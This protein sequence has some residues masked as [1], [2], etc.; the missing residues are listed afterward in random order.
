M[1]SNYTDL[2][3]MI[4]ETLDRDDLEAQL[5]NFI[6][7]AESRHRREIR[8]RE[9]IKRAVAPAEERYLSLPNGFLEMKTL[10][11]LTDPVTAVQEVNL[12][13]MNRTR[14]ET[15]GKPRFYTVH[16]E[17]EFDRK[18][19]R[20]YTA[21]MIYYA[22]LTPLSAENPTNALLTRLPDVYLYGAL[23]AA[24][25]FLE[26]DERLAVW[27]QLYADARE[28]AN[29]MDRAKAGPLVAR[30]YGATP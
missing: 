27:S 26:H 29:A 14:I 12:D 28:Q 9:M 5:D 20:E 23:I 17:I 19:D 11:L 3:T 22:A 21:E 8:I 25:P 24:A 18:P 10:R 2:K 4:A 6:R 30:V 13:V 7:F 16:S 15:E 1:P